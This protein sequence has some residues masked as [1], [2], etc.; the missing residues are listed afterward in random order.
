MNQNVRK[1]TEGAM[2]A[3]IAGVLLLINRQTAGLLEGMLLFLFPLPMVFYSARYGMKN[4]WIVFAAICFLAFFLGTPQSFFY[5]LSESLIGIIYGSGVYRKT[6]TRKLLLITIVMA[7]FVDVATMIVFARFFG[8]D[9]AAEMQEY[10]TIAGQVFT[11][12]G[13]DQPASVMTDQFIRTIFIVSAILTGVLEGYITHFFSRLMLKRFRVPLP[14]S[15]SLLEYYPPKWTG[16]VAIAGTIMYF[17]AMTHTIENEVTAGLMEGAGMV[18]MFYLIFY[19]MIAAMLMI[20]IML[21]RIR[22][23][24][25]MLIS[26]AL[27]MISSIVLAVVGFLYITT[28]F[29]GK[30]VKGE[31]FHA[32]KNR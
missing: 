10:K 11:S 20:R 5:V 24:S 13:I 22:A 29:H 6:E 28:D 7:V 14:P 3:A 30:L 21:P 12:A 9:I 2:M 19:G 1:L 15:T 8:Y 17:Y 31:M 23:F 26:L 18:G 25:L 4:S 32:S 16:Y 27:L